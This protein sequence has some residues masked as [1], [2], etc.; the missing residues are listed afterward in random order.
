MCFGNKLRVAD[1][2]RSTSLAQRANPIRPENVEPN[3]KGNDFG[4][5]LCHNAIVE[6][7]DPFRNDRQD[8]VG[9][10]RPPRCETH[11]G[12]ASNKQ[13]CLFQADD[14]NPE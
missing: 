14:G 5:H 12:F 4:S 3:L 8:A 1:A 10:Q 2:L 7:A 13:G 6:S 9:G 11:H